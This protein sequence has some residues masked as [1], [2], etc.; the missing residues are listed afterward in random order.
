VEIANL[1]VVRVAAIPHEAD[2]ILPVDPD[3]PGL[4]DL[5]K[6]ISRRIAKVSDRGGSIDDY[7]LAKCRVGSEPIV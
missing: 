4:A 3:L 7:E 5:L 6:I 2:A 1:H